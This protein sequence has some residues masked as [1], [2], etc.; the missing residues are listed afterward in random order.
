MSASE[1]GLGGRVS[2]AGVHVEERVGEHRQR[3]SG[4]GIV[5]VDGVVGGP[6]GRDPAGGL[7]HHGFGG[8]D[9]ASEERRLEG[10]AATAPRVA[11]SD[12]RPVSEQPGEFAALEVALRV[13]VGVR[14]EDALDFVRVC[15]EDARVPGH[16]ES[17]DVA[18]LEATDAVSYYDVASVDD[19]YV[20]VYTQE[21]AT[22]ANRRL[23][24]TFTRDS[25]VT[26]LPVVY[27]AD[28]TASF[29]VVGAP[30]DLQ[31]AVAD[32]REVA[33]FEVDRLGDYDPRETGY[34]AALTDRQRDVV[35]GAV[36]AGYYD[37]PRTASQ[38][39]VAAELDCAP[40]TVAEHLRKAEASLA[41]AAI[42]NDAGL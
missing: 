19:D 38:D 29:T 41:R 9:A 28:G 16:R 20:Y 33:D 14:D 3:Q 25:L 6:V 30:D 10:F 23:R 26:T 5:D 7:A 21:V 15:D 12:Q 42:R 35:A 18:V 1:R 2:S 39:D 11:V 4:R 31:A 24:A 34:A 8:L 36:A 40:S 13:G 32:A 27:R 17:D 22:D 37:V